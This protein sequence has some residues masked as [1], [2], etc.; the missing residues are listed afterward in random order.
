MIRNRLLHLTVA[1]AVLT[2]LAGAAGSAGAVNARTGTRLALH[3][4]TTLVLGTTSEPDTLNPEIT[5]V[6]FDFTSGIFDAL[7]KV[8]AHDNFI[9]DLATSWSISPDNLTYTFHLRHGVKW[10]DGTPFTAKDMLFTYHQIKNPKNNNYST[11][12]WSYVTRVDT[13]DDY[14]LILHTAKV[15]APFLLQMGTTPILPAHYF[16]HSPSFLKAGTY[17]HDPWNRKPFGIGPYMVTEW[18]SADHITLTPN[19]YYWGQRPYFQKLVYKIVPSPNTLLVQLRTNDV[20]LAPVT[21]QQV[22]QAQNIP[23]T[24]LMSVA[25]Q[26]WYHIDLKQWGFLR[27]QKVRVALDDA[28]PKDEIVKTVLHGYGQ[29]AYG[30]IA[31]ISWAYDPNVPTHPFNLDT[32]RALL[33]SDGFTKGSD[34][35]LQKGGKE[36][37]IQLWY[38][39]DD[40]PG[41]QIDQILKYEWGQI[42]VKV[43]L[44]N[45]DV[46]TI[47]GPSGPLFSHQMTGISYAWFNSDDPNDRFYWNSAEIPNSPTGAGGN[48]VGYFYR[49]SFQ[50]Q[51]DNLTNA[52]LAT[53]DRA[54]RKAIY[55]KIETLLAQQVPVIFIDWQPLLF[56]APAKLKGFTPNAFQYGLL[57]N[58]QQWH[59]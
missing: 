14:T 50:K 51:I 30:D 4:S 31:P 46:S 32:A 19:K 15:Y 34:G 44:H 45:Q 57:W 39:S 56:V 21:Q 36:L 12:E 52:G 42:G 3:A 54:K 40:A 1:T 6:G 41:A 55:A 38:A 28:T 24:V 5:Q 35:F 33:A 10:A 11:G 58:I 8:D 47:F 20:D 2:L 18:K 7:V 13:P 43:D 16:A 59:Y 25:S 17:N 53:V 37:Y 22:K 27:D 29:V 23:G 49:F 9:P 26:G 48:D